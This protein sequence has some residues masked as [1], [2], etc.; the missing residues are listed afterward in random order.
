M[1]F[2]EFPI[3]MT[4]C[5]LWFYLPYLFF[6]RIMNPLPLTGLSSSSP[7][8]LDNH[9][10]TEIPIRVER[11]KILV[12][13]R[14]GNAD[15]TFLVDTGAPFMIDSTLAV[16]MGYSA[17]GSKGL[18]DAA[19]N[20]TRVK[21]IRVPAFNLGEVS[22]TDRP[23]LVYDF[24]NSLLGCFGIDGII[25]SN[26]LQQHVVQ[27]DWEAGKLIITDSA[28][29]LGLKPGETIRI[30]VNERQASPYAPVRLQDNIRIWSLLDT[31]SDEFFTICQADLSSV[32]EKGLL[33]S[34]PLSQSSGSASLGLLGGQ[35]DVRGWL[36][37][38]GML[39]LDHVHIADNVAIQSNL[40]NDSNIGMQLLQRGNLTIDY[41]GE[42]IWF[43]PYADIPGYRYE[44][45]GLG[46][47]PE[48]DHWIIREVWSGTD[49]ERLGIAVGDTLLQYGR[50]NLSSEGICDI[51]FQ[52]P[53]ERRGDR[54]EVVVRNVNPW[55]E[56]RYILN[57][58]SVGGAQ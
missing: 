52:L 35:V 3:L 28:R 34:P 7:D 32:R 13:V 4:M 49:A 37:D 6:V 20:S 55:R 41:P 26:L 18:N 54:L 24:R 23:A 38:A 25:G 15:R 16:E 47:V 9:E 39:R 31:G 17:I 27:F 5:A 30:R 50:V 56:E 46:F 51:L 57:R 14:V 43:Q 42:R 45:F 11:D 10:Y 2:L 36:I 21:T 8:R 48:D 53:A 1:V 44:H 40:D 22:F 12:T 29:R 33:A 19:G 58:I